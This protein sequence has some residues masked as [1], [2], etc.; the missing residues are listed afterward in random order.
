M[1][2]LRQYAHTSHKYNVYMKH[3][4]LTSKP[5]Y[6]DNYTFGFIQYLFNMVLL[7]FSTGNTLAA[8]ND[9]GLLKY[10]SESLY[11]ILYIATFDFNRQLQCFCAL[12]VILVKITFALPQ[13]E[14]LGII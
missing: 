3:F 6:S 11:F 2:Y 10:A 12:P 7:T 1:Y 9:N 13:R 5:L 4:A 14:E 8:V